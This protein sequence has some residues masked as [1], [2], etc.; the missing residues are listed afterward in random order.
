MYRILYLNGHNE[1]KRGHSD[2]VE[3]ALHWVSATFGFY[4]A[5]AGAGLGLF[6]IYVLAHRGAIPNIFVGMMLALFVVMI[7]AGLALMTCLG[8][9]LNSSRYLY[10]LASVPAFGLLY[11]TVH[12]LLS[13]PPGAWLFGGM[14]FAALSHLLLVWLMWG[15]T[16][17]EK[18][19]EAEAA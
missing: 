17:P 1:D 18:V 10:A 14:A 19:P 16:D 7:I 11:L 6:F 8:L 15:H 13:G 5:Q 2:T 12:V 3:K 9:A 4:F